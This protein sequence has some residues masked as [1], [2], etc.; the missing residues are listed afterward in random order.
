MPKASPSKHSPPI[1]LY[2][3]LQDM[4]YTSQGWVCEEHK[5]LCIANFLRRYS[6][7]SILSYFTPYINYVMYCVASGRWY[8][9]YSVCKTAYNHVCERGIWFLIDLYVTG[10]YQDISS[11]AVLV[12][13]LRSWQETTLFPVSVSS[14][15][16]QGHPDE[17]V[18]S[19]MDGREAT[20]WQSRS[21]LGAPVFSD[22]LW[23][24]LEFK[25]ELIASSQLPVTVNIIPPNWPQ[26][27]NCRLA[28][29][30]RKTTGFLSST[31]ANKLSV[32]T[33][34]FEVIWIQES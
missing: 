15:N 9:F 7:S 27:R 31:K 20:E 34:E 32:K 30:A 33:G 13:A 25:T 1:R 3:W 14:G 8:V 24:L 12:W 21:V 5:A 10:C 11:P 4:T 23:E 29:I 19:W 2:L 16:E 17:G 26:L 6:P 22:W 28:V 18:I